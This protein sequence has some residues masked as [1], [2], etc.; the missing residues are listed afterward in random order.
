MLA[1]AASYAY[2]IPFDELRDNGWSQD[3]TYIDSPSHPSKGFCTNPLSP[4]KF[5]TSVS[6][7]L[8]RQI[9]KQSCATG[10]VH[11]GTSVSFRKF[12]EALVATSKAVETL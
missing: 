2:P 7:K 1:D 12:I 3:N 5:N 8:R 11:E 4:S 6:G 10:V 9:V